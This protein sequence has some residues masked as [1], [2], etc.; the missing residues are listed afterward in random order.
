MLLAFSET[1][2]IQPLG[3]G[4]P[5]IEL[6]FNMCGYWSSEKLFFSFAIKVTHVLGSDALQ[7]NLTSAHPQATSFH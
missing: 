7:L 4:N 6:F 2:S 1:P 5:L 3:Q